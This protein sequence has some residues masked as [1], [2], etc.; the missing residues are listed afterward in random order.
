MLIVVLAGVL[1]VNADFGLDPTVATL[2]GLSTQRVLVIPSATPS[3]PPTADPLSGPLYKTWQ[4]PADLPKT[5]KLGQVSIPGTISG[6]KARPAGLYLPPAALVKNP[7]ALPLVIMMM[8]EPGNPDPVPQAKVL[9]AMAARDKGL[10]PI[11]LV[12]DQ[13]GNPF[14][15]SLCLNTTQYG[16]VEKYI[17]EDVV[18]WARTHLHVLQYPASWTET[19]AVVTPRDPSAQKTRASGATCSTFRESHTRDGAPAHRSRRPFSMETGPRIPRPGPSTFSPVT[20]I[21]T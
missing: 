9:D 1:G 18:N 11:V 5:G 10:A 14:V 8:G 21:R 19:P 3:A 12:A 13:L 2:A 20:S 4:P 7:P 6:F 15:D 16:N 17:T